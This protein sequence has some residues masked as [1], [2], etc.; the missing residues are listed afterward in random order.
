[1]QDIPLSRFERLEVLE[2]EL[3]MAGKGEGFV[4]F[5][6]YGDVGEGMRIAYINGALVPTVVDFEVVSVEKPI[7]SIWGMGLQRVF[8]GRVGSEGRVG[9]G[10]R[11]GR[12]AGKSM[13]HLRAPFPYDKNVM[14]GLTIATVVSDDGSGEWGFV[15]AEDVG[16]VTVFGPAV[17]EV[18]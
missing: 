8:G 17:I 18:G 14:H 16:A 12:S 5:L 9:S 1:M 15:G 10:R 11:V 7:P 13:T 2:V 3:G 4:E 6:A